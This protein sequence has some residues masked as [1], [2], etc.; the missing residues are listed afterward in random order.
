MKKRTIEQP[1]TI[2]KKRRIGDAFT[3]LLAA[4][5]EWNKKP[6]RDKTATI[7]ALLI[8]A[9]K[10]DYSELVL[11]AFRGTQRKEA[12]G[13]EKGGAV[14]DVFGQPGDGV[15]V[16]N[17]H[18]LSIRRF[19]QPILASRVGK[20]G[21]GGDAILFPW[22]E[23]RDRFDNIH[24]SH[25]DK[26][27]FILRNTQKLLDYDKEFA[28][29][30]FPNDLL[31]DWFVDASRRVFDAI[32]TDVILEKDIIQ[33]T[34]YGAHFSST[35]G[36]SKKT[37]DD[38][39]RRRE[40]NNRILKNMTAVLVAFHVLTPIGNHQWD[41]FQA[42]GT[43]A[44]EGYV[45]GEDLVNLVHL[46]EIEECITRETT[47]TNRTIAD[48]WSSAL[49]FPQGGDE[50]MFEF[51]GGKER[52]AEYY[53]HEDLKL[54][55]LL[56]KDADPSVCGEDDWIHWIT[57]WKWVKQFAMTAM[58]KEEKFYVDRHEPIVNILALL[59]KTSDETTME[60]TNLLKQWKKR[61]VAVSA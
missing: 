16:T 5:R 43:F 51:D 24:S 32:Q 35:E 20:T 44:F 38:A 19:F 36:H 13:N 6:T 57:F 54:K 30:F 23:V 4:V 60:A 41:G 7:E 46:L 2:P 8:E 52:E 58:K 1:G 33:C 27:N 42:L 55:Y 61:Y 49:D 21:V 48:E 29:L 56:K 34:K 37:L 26:L 45:E 10:V 3:R 39:T 14:D 28:E 40:E 47:N 9:V 31:P 18:P 12:N 22:D 11:S 59:P 53:T 25:L 15:T 50:L 17:N